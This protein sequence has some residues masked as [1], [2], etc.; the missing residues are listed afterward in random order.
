MRWEEC[1]V[2]ACKYCTKPLYMYCNGIFYFSLT[3]YDIFLFLKI[4]L[5]SKQTAA[6]FWVSLLA[7]VPI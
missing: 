5:L 6:Y 1:D 3:N 2:P 7:K 4:V